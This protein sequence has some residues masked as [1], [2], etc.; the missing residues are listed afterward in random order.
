MKQNGIVI[1]VKGNTADI[2]IQR[3][4]ACGGNCAS[5]ASSCAKNAVV[6]AE[7]KA[8]AVQGDRVELEMPSSRV[9]STAALVYVMPLIMLIAGVFAGNMIFKSE[10]L[11]ILCGFL[12]MAAAYAALIAFS[13]RN[14]SKYALRVTKI[15]RERQESPYSGDGK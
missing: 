11:G 5:C 4:S 3:E 12:C 8:G 2:R 14:R 15:L 1:A 9:L 6:A 7:N 10:A 13:K